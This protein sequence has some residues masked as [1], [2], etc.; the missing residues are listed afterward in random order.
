MTRWPTVIQDFQTSCYFTIT[1]IS[2]EILFHDH[3]SSRQHQGSPSETAHGWQADPTN[4]LASDRIWKMETPVNINSFSAIFEIHVKGAKSQRGESKLLTW[5]SHSS[6]LPAALGWGWHRLHNYQVRSAW[7]SYK[8][9]IWICLFTGLDCQQKII[10][11][12]C[13]HITKPVSICPVDREI[14]Q[15][16][17]TL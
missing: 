12:G 17:S 1:R 10:W 4:R 5:G 15:A 14:Y 9:L 3:I 16:Y 7:F 8:G 13:N 11:K 6:L 2:A